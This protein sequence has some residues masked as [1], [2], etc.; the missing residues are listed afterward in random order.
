MANYFCTIR[1][2]YFHVKDDNAFRQ[3]MSRVYGCEDNVELWEEKD[4]DGRT[5]FGFGTYGGIS[6]LRDLDDDI[7]D[8]SSYD[9]F[10][11]QLQAFVADDDAII[12]LESGNEKLR[13][14]VGFATIITSSDYKYMDITNL[15]IE[16][17][18]KMLCNPSWQT[19]C[20]Y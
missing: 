14:V 11:D 8:D 1:T 3:M 18:E 19:R 20:E 2:N 6:G 12:I 16:Q 15:A 5:V 7:V 9:D 10:I 4:K 17:A 13:Y